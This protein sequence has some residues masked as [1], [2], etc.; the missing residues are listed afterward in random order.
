MPHKITFRAIQ[1]EFEAG[2]LFIPATAADKRY[3]NAFCGENNGKYLTVTVNGSRG[4]KTYDQVKTVWGLIEIYFEAQYNRKPTQ[5]ESTTMY[6]SFIQ[7]YAD[8]EPSL[9]EKGKE[10]CVTLSNMSKE[11]AA[12]FIQNIMN[13]IITECRLSE[14]LQCDV[15]EL[16]E[17]FVQYKGTLPSDPVD[18]DKNGVLLNREDWVKM[19]P[20]SHASGLTQGLEVAHIVSK[21]SDEEDR[22]ECW[23]WI[24]LTHEEHIGIQHQNGWEELIELYPHIEGRVKRARELAGKLEKLNNE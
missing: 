9:L 24:M 22:Y 2:Y 13:D 14:G 15:K 4:N 11:Q 21:G 23:N 8:T 3:V 17:A 19:N 1:K 20:C 5:N 7:Q 12:R 18:Y 6:M 16:Y 10:V